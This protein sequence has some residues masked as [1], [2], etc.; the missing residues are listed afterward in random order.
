ML[1]SIEDKFLISIGRDD[2][3]VIQWKVIKHEELNSS[4]EV[5]VAFE[6][7][8]Y[9]FNAISAAPV[10]DTISIFYYHIHI[11]LVYIL[12]FCILG[13]KKSLF[14]LKTLGT[15]SNSYYCGLEGIVTNGGGFP[16]FIGSDLKH[17][18]IELPSN[19]QKTVS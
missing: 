7:L 5:K 18:A 13:T 1:Y 4:K 16:V 15:T 14:H 17:T 19:S 6:N 11:F 2:N 10:Q 12:N 3:T 9:Q 8:E